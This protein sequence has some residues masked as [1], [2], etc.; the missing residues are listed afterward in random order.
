MSIILSMLLLSE[1]VGLDSELLLGLFNKDLK[2][3]V[4]LN[5]FLPDRILLQP[6]EVLMLPWE[7]CITMIG[8]GMPT[9]PSKV[10]IGLVIKMPFITCVEKHLLQFYNFNLMECH[11]QE[12]N[13]EKSIKE[14]LEVNLYNTEKVHIN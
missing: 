12:Q 9:I 10:V 14:H 7:I 13:K 5:C 3:L 2:L 8:G 4:F 6:K 11:F 1:L